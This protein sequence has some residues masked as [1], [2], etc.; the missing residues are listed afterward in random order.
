MPPQH[1]EGWCVALYLPFLGF[2][3][4]FF[5]FRVLFVLL[6]I[7]LFSIRGVPNAAVKKIILP[8]KQL[9]KIGPT[10]SNSYKFLAFNDL[11]FLRE[12]KSVDVFI[13]VFGVHYVYAAHN[14]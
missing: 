12:I 2:A 1:G 14:A 13:V 3:F 4:F 11:L 7:C 10:T 6:Q 9:E 8:W 5:L